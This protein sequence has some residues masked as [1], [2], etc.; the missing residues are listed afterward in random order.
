M[1]RVMDRLL[2]RYRLLS[3]REGAYL[4]KNGIG[5]WKCAGTVWWCFDVSSRHPFLGGDDRATRRSP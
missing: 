1:G 5:S 3:S 2:M 4:R